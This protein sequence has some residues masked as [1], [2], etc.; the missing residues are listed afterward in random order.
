[1]TNYEMDTRVPLIVKPTHSM[2]GDSRRDQLVESVDIY[3][4][5]C[6][7]AGLPMPDGLAGQSFAG[8]VDDPDRPGKQAAY[9][10]FLRYGF[11]LNEGDREAMGYTVRTKDWRYVEWFHSDSDQCI[12][13]ELYDIT[14]QGLE[15]ENLAGRSEHAEIERDLADKL[16]AYRGATLPMKASAV[17]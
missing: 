17:R 16:K 13:R 5:L 4:T 8:Q 7:L 11:W 9:S 6:D 12:A 1:M 14:S 10:Q 2:T 3:P 15:Q